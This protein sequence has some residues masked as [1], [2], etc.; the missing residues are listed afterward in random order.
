MRRVLAIAATAAIGGALLVPA[1]PLAEDSPQPPTAVLEATP[2]TVT[3][4]QPVKLDS[5]KS[6]PGTGAIVGHLWDLDGNGTFETDTGTEPTVE[7][8]PKDAGPLT[9]Q[10]RIVDDKGLNADTH[11]DLTVTAPPPKAMV[12]ADPA[13]AAPAPADAAPADPKPDPAQSP[14]PPHDSGGNP[15]PAA[16][17]EPSAPAEPTKPA[18]PT[19][20]KTPPKAFHTSVPVHMTAAPS[21][22][23]RHQL[24]QRPRTVPVSDVHAA[25][26]SGVTIK[27]FAFSPGTTTVHVGDTITWTNQDSIAHTATASDGSFDTGLL[28]KGKSGSHTFT[29]AGTIAYICSVHPSMK[30]TVTVAAASG[31]SGSGSSGGSGS[32]TTTPSTPSAA[33][34]SNLPHTGFDLLVVVLLAGVMTGVGT[35][36]RWRIGL[37]E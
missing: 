33:T 16:P 30:G 27:N 10:V 22:V 21:L 7:T 25:A 11:V 23:P 19:E 34:G 8:T 32:G 15:Q 6:T 18:G 2:T 5:S 3:A 20:P 36:M 31:S 29:K 37:A 14:A 4:G 1:V 35:L 26:S 9:V 28:Q 13:P 24:V 17:A 12:P